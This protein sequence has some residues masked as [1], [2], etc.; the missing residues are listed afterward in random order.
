M[1]GCFGGALICTKE[2]GI[3]PFSGQCPGE[4]LRSSVEQSS[5]VADTGPGTH[6]EGIPEPTRTFLDRSVAGSGWPLCSVIS[7]RHR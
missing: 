1:G 3:A 5:F 4:G 7:Y 2:T 6:V